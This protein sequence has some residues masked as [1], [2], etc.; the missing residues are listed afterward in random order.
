[1]AVANV[2]IVLARWGYN[3]L[4]V[5]FDLEAPGLEKFF[6]AFLDVRIR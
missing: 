3:V 5:D 6:H 1:M 4:A 2:A